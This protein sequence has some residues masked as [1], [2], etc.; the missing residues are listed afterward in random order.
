MR[1]AQKH[2]YNE[3]GFQQRVGAGKRK[4]P[5]GHGVFQEDT[6]E[7][8]EE[9]HVK[10]VDHPEEIA[11]VLQHR[12]VVPE[13]DQDDAYASGN[14]DGGIPSVVGHG[15]QSGHG[16]HVD[17]SAMKEDA[18]P[19]RHASWIKASYQGPCNCLDT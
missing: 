12:P 13:H 11:F 17:D 10:G 18:M 7:K 16:F 15:V 6:G 9:R 5:Q 8:E 4:R 19:C 2:E 14:I 3:V 1:D